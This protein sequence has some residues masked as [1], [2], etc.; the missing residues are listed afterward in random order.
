M[1]NLEIIEACFVKGEPVEVGVIL[2]N[3]ENGTAAQ[4]LTSGRARIAIAKPKPEPKPEPKKKPSKKVSQ[5][6]KKLDASSDS[7]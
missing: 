4:L 3:V 5:K 7:K 1:K 2:E 6:A